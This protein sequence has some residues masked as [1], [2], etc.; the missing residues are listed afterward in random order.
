M[1]PAVATIEHI[2]TRYP[3]WRIVFVGRNVSLEGSNV[4]SEEY[5]L[6]QS[7]GVPF[8]SLITGRIKRDFSFYTVWSMMKIPIGFFHACWIVARARPNVI[9]SFGGYVAVPVVFAAWMMRI[10]IITHEQTTKPG[11]A[12]RLIAKLAT[13]VCTSFPGQDGVFSR[14]VIYTGLP[15]RRS[16]FRSGSAPVVHVDSDR[17]MLFITGG[18][19]G[20]VSVND[21]VYQALPNLLSTYTI[22]HQVG[23]ASYARAQEI[24]RTGGQKGMARYYPV[25]YL[26]ASAYSWVMHHAELV[27]GRSGANTVIEIAARAQIALFIP[28]PWA[29]GGEQHS[30]AQWLANAGSAQILPQS[31]LTAQSLVDTIAAMMSNKKTYKAAAEKFAKTVPQDGADRLV[32]VLAS[33]SNKSTT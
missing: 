23:R 9:M 1:T 20:S 30:N 24:K 27:I 21:V 12:N 14:Q 32:D 8:V 7:L 13:A 6:M 4:A 16:T 3:A 2:K 26:D 28:L 29:A 33:I 5:S 19:T 17:P 18:S 15:I 31:A 25:A 10:P 22:I 11:L